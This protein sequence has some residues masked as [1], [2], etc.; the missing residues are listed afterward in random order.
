[1]LPVM[2]VHGGSAMLSATSY[3]CAWITKAEH[4]GFAEKLPHEG[5]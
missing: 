2:F 5:R 3:G 4:W 1:M